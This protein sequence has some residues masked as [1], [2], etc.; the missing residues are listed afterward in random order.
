[1]SSLG[2]CELGLVSGSLGTGSAGKHIRGRG[3][4]TVTAQGVRGE[5]NHTGGSRQEHV[6]TTGDESGW[7]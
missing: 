2:K 5:G 3:R 7:K 4:W 6:V 1:M